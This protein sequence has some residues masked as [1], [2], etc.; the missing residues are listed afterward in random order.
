MLDG[1]NDGTENWEI[2]KYIGYKDFT[3]FMSSDDDFF[4]IRRFDRMHARVLL[5]QQARISAL[6]QQLDSL[7]ESLSAR[8]AK[9]VDN[10]SVRDDVPERKDLIL[11]QI[12][13]SLVEYGRCF[14]CIRGIH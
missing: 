14:P 2:R 7:D 8:E 13:T 12:A 5:Y 1:I 10:G 6:E 11:G 4:A 3:K 9:D